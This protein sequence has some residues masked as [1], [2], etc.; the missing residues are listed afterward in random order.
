MSGLMMNYKKYYEQV[1]NMS[2]PIPPSQL[3]Q[4]KVDLSALSKYAREKGIPV[5]Q[6]SDEEKAL[7]ISKA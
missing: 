2:E 3:P 4:V 6:L 7:F 1:R 5:S